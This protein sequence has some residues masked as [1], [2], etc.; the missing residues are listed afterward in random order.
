MKFKLDYSPPTWTPYIQDI[1]KM[2]DVWNELR[3]CDRREYLQQKAGESD[4]FYKIRLKSS[5]F[6]DR[7]RRAIQ[8]FAGV[9][10]LN[11]QITDATP[12]EIQNQLDDVDG[13][14]S[15]FHVW[16]NRTCQQLLRD[17]C[18]AWFVAWDEAITQWKLV[19][20]DPLSIKAPIIIDNKLIALTVESSEQVV[21]GY[22][23][24]NV[25]VLYRHEIVESEDQS[26]VYYQYTKYTEERS[27]NNPGF[28]PVG[29][30]I[31]P[32]DATGAVLPE[33]PFIWLSLGTEKTPLSFEFSHFSTL[34]DLTIQ[35]FNKI[36]EL[37]TAESSCNI[38]TLTR[39][40][41]GAAPDNP[42]NI[43]TGANAIIEVTDAQFGGKVEFLEPT[44]QAIQTTHQRNQDREAY[45]DALA[46][47]FVTGDT[48][49][50]TATQVQV[51]ISAVQAQLLNLVAS[52][53]DAIENTFR[54][55]M[56]YASPLP[57][58]DTGGVLIDNEAIRPAIDVP[59]LKYW[60]E[61]T[62]LGYLERAKFLEL[63][64][65]AGTFPRGFKI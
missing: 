23:T 39:Y 60:Q 53:Q 22:S 18:V 9:L 26:F 55:I 32:R 29:P 54:L 63:L 51:E 8:E 21:S 43:Y 58:D 37:N 48:V 38:Q 10:A 35:Q 36:S 5:V 44:G 2:R 14:G 20:A 28:I 56:L 50:K 34:A 12:S 45:M 64:Q 11:S 57:S 4:E 41:P 62:D 49:E 42:P 31:V 52:I 27:P 47:Q 25:R 7:V 30:P 1:I 3:L 59:T 24:E 65:V 17:G 46:R 33:I 6:Q 61:L 19:Y 15:N 16:L 13:L 40:W